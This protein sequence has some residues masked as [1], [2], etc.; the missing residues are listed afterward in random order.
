[1]EEDQR[2]AQ[3]LKIVIRANIQWKPVSPDTCNTAPGFE[4][5]DYLYNFA[6]NHMPE[7]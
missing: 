7:L 2:D 1:M 6:L 3:I 4:L 5:T